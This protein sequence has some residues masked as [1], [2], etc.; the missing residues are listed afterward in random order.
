MCGYLGVNAIP[1][2]LVE[3]M[4]SID[5][6]SLTL[7]EKSYWLYFENFPINID[8]NDWSKQV[9]KPMLLVSVEV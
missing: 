3:D 1:W 8:W 9:L 2:V 5:P 7:W 6:F 4:F